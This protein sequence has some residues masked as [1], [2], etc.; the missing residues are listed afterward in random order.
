MSKYSTKQFRDWAVQQYKKNGDLYTK[1]TVGNY[2]SSLNTILR[3]LG[4]DKKPGLKDVFSCKDIKEFEALYKE[5]FANPNFA[6]LNIK[7][8]NI[9]SAALN[10]YRRYVRYLEA[11][12]IGTVEKLALDNQ[13][14]EE[15]TKAE[16]L[17]D[18][19]LIARIKEKDNTLCRERKV[20]SINYIRDQEI[21]EYAVRRASGKCDLCECEAPFNK[22]DGTPY[23]E[24][25]HVEWLSRGGNDSIE[26]VVALC[27]NCHRKIHVLNCEE[28]TKALKKRLNAYYQALMKE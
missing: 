22:K 18:T 24:A 4:L 19:E 12:K 5:I 1:K 3:K 2:S 15:R 21:V 16:Q 10:L 14:K 26:N 27:P 17:P 7:S 9:D 25:H 28:D 13:A 11:N 6:Q 8:D 23:L 20:V